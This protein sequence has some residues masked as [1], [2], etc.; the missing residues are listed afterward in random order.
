M[1]RPT[2]WLI[3]GLDNRRNT[4]WRCVRVGHGCPA[5]PA[6]KIVSKIRGIAIGT[7]PPPLLNNDTYLPTLQRRYRHRSPSA[8][9]THP[10][11]KSVASPSAPT[12]PWERRA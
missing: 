12:P 8:M 7:D 1:R 9:T 11:R 6:T 4:T 10:P 5:L 3:C 2:S